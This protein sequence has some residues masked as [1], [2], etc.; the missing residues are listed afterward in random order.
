MVV[1]YHHFRKPPHV[2]FSSSLFRLGWTSGFFPPEAWENPESKN[3]R[4][5]PCD[6]VLHPSLRK[7]EYH[8]S[9]S[10]HTS[11]GSKVTPPNN[12]G[13]T[14]FGDVYRD[15]YPRFVFE[16]LSNI[17]PAGKQK[18]YQFNVFSF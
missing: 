9:R 2:V 3:R 11:M 17:A 6:S 16:I 18:I 5:N 7:G 4:G 15:V 1:G 13:T 10:N 8:R 14:G 12:Q